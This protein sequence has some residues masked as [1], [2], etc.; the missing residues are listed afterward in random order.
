M[1]ISKR[2]RNTVRGGQN[3]SP[4]EIERARPINFYLVAAAE[5]T[6]SEGSIGNKVGYE[7]RTA[8]NYS[9]TDWRCYRTGSTLSIKSSTSLAIKPLEIS[10]VVSDECP[11]EISS[12]ASSEDGRMTC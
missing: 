8:P 2:N 12:A 4:R 9:R 5:E 1:D 6:R 7:G 3:R 10:S 11:L